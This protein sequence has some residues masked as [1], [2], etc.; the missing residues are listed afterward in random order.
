MTKNFFEALYACTIFKLIFM[1]FASFIALYLRGAVRCKK[2]PLLK[3]VQLSA[4]TGTI[5]KSLF[6]FPMHKNRTSATP[7]FRLTECDSRDKIEIVILRYDE[8]EM[9]HEC[10]PFSFLSVF[11]GVAS[12]KKNSPCNKRKIVL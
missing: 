7:A 10:F 2:P 3:Q 12:R 4:Q 8:L 5:S 6:L 1:H 9:L 11:Y